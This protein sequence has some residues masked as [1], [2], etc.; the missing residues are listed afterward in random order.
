MTR[1][2][3]QSCEPALN[4]TYSTSVCSQYERQGQLLAS[5]L[6]TML[7][8]IAY[9]A[10]LRQ[11]GHCTERGTQHCGKTSTPMGS[12]IS[13]GQKRGKLT[14]SGARPQQLIT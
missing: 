4:H 2:R 13:P 8:A 6:G 3:L 12:N 7:S 14:W 9:L 10:A 5:A 11:R 1:V